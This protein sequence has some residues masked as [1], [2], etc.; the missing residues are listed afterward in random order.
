[1]EILENRKQWLAAFQAGWLAYLRATG[2]FD[3][4]RYPR[5]TNLKGIPGAGIDLAASKLALI[6]SAGAYAPRE[7][8][9]FDASNP[10]GD[11]EIR[12]L[13]ATTAP[14]TLAF[15]HEHY[16]QEAVT[17]DPEVLIPLGHLRLLVN[18]GVIGEL[19]PSVIS[20]MGYQPYVTRVV[21]ETIPAIL[22]VCQAEQVRA[23]LLVPA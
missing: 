11:Y 20:F 13:P 15:A 17:L 18:E 6:S 3:W 21:D 8:H 7:Q 19:A 22:E 16:D 23:A 12:T 10:L 14:A 2:E 9:P 4:K 1:M 5:P